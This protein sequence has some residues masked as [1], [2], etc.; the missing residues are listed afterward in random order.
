M[1]KIKFTSVLLL[2]L[3]L[4]ACEHEKTYNVQP[5]P[6]VDHGTHQ[7]VTQPNGSQVVVVKDEKSGAEFFMEL[8]MFQSLMNMA[9]GMS[10]V[11]GY[12]NQHR[13][14]N[15]WNDRQTRYRSNTTT[16][17]NNYYGNRGNTTS[18]SVSE[19]IKYNESNGFGRKSTP[20]QSKGFSGNR[21][22]PPTPTNTPPP[23]Y[24]PSPGFTN[25]PTPRPTTP[26]KPSSGFGSSG[27]RPSSGFGG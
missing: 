11:H 8:L 23:T 19:R 25:K 13:Y 4:T 21:F 26:S 24:K 17:I 27:S 18:P 12:Y 9:G 15:D 22:S 1:K 10:N 3:W 14:D 6:V 5:A 16:V 7:V 2:T 20:Q